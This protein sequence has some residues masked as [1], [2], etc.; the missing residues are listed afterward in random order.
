MQL[1]V[2][3]TAQRAPNT[4]GLLVGLFGVSSYSH[5]IEG[6]GEADDPGNERRAK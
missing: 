5:Q 2:E 4:V 1:T 6:H 3:E